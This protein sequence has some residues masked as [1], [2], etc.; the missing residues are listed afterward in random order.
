LAPLFDQQGKLNQTVLRLAAK[1][2]KVSKVNRRKSAGIPPAV[3]IEALRSYNL[4]PAI[5]FLNT[6]RQCDEAALDASLGRRAVRAKN[7]EARRRLLEEMA[8]VYPELRGYRHWEMVLT[9]GIA[10]HHAGH[11]PAWK[12]VIERLMSTGLLNAIFATS[13]V[14]AGV[15]YP[16]RTVLFTN[17]DTRGS[18]G[19]TP[20][21]AS[22]FQQMTGRAGRR[23][24]DK[25]GF[26]IAA[27]GPHQNLTHIASLLKARPDRAESQFQ[28]TYTT[29]LNLL[30]AFGSFAHIR[31][32]VE[33]SFQQYANNLMITRLERRKVGIEL[34]TRSTLHRQAWEPFERRAHVLAHFNY[35]NFETQSV[36]DSG[37]VLADLRVDRPLLVGE[38]INRGLMN[39][40]DA[41]LL[42]GLIASLASDSDRNFG[43]LSISD[44]LY[45]LLGRLMA[46][47]REVTGVEYNHGVV[48]TDTEINY[49]A[50]ATAMHWAQGRSWDELVTRTGAE[51]GDLVRM[52][53]RTG[54]SLLQICGVKAGLASEAVRVASRAATQV[55]REPVRSGL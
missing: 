10:S 19:W 28:A 48:N 22:Q 43:D 52:F 7:P 30:D 21:G 9:S 6:R 36:T 4:L 41:P 16:A 53:S 2:G 26:V 50:A 51:E 38:A 5:I 20:L 24:R 40:I 3:M 44:D 55:L 54:E 32:I 17:S 15:D 37:R 8:N 14:A 33:R 34:E 11:L 49:S 23:G 25:V 18:N 35:L 13:T 1:N 47:A 31:E 42:A 46:I 27:P 12:L 45:D 39:S 29:L